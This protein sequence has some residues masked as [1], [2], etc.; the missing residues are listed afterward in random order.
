MK[1][2]LIAFLMLALFLTACQNPPGMHILDESIPVLI[3]P[4]TQYPYT[5]KILVTDCASGETREYTDGQMHDNIRMRFEGIRCT[6]EKIKEGKEYTPLYE[7][8]FVATDTTVTVKVLSDSAYLLDEYR[9][10][11]ITSGVDLIYLGSLFAA[12]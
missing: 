6:R 1:K 9:Y 8:T 12:E 5:E 4:T 7:V 3:D 2:I 10:D 11:A